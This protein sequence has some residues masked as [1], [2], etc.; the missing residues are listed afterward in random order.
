L[1]GAAL[2]DP[3][4]YV[5][6]PYDNEGLRTVDFRYW[7]VKPNQRTEMVWPELGLGYGVNSRWTTELFLSWLGSAHQAVRPVTLNWQNDVLLTQG[8]YPFDLALHAQ[9]IKDRAA[10]HQ[11]GVNWG[12]V[13]QTEVGRTQINFNLFFDQ[14]LR[15]EV[16]TPTKAQYQWQLR[17]H[18]GSGV[19]LGLQGF[20]ELGPWNNWAPANKQSHR[21]GPAA[22]FD[23]RLD[24]EPTL[25]LQAAW[26]VGKTYGQRGHMFTLRG[27]IDF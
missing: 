1:A 10:P 15:A 6:M 12:P 3:G 7:T 9:V 17:Q 8:Q 4:Y 11:L 24:G 19:Q 16:P 22:F 13:F 26:L 14:I 21:A 2:A 20:G 5:V 25:K 23:A 18:N 27:H